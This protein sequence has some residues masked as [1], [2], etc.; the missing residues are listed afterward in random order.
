MTDRILVIEDEPI[1]RS[2]IVEVLE[3]AGFEVV[4]A[5]R[6]ENGLTVLSETSVSLVISD[7]VMPGI[8]GLQL[9]ETVRADHPSLPVVLV[10]GAGTYGNLTQALASG[11]SGIVVKPFSHADL[12]RA[13]HSA[14]GRARASEAE[15]RDRIV[16]PTVAAALA[17]AIEARD[18]AMHGHCERL[19][20]LAVAIAVE[21]GLPEPEQETIRL[22]GLLHDVGKI[23]IADSI[24]LK[25]GPLSEEEWVVMRTHPLIGDRLLEPLTALGEVRLGVRHHHERWDGSGYPDALAGEAIP[26]A[27]RVV[28][29]ADA[30]EAMSANRPYRKA[31]RPA[32]I[33]RQLEEGLGGQWD[34]APAGVALDLIR[35]GRLVFGPEGLRLTSHE[36]AVS[37]PGGMLSVL[38]VEDD[39]DHASLVSRVI[40]RA[41]DDVRVIHAADM[42]SAVKLLSDCTWSLAVLDHNLPDGSGLELLDQLR[43]ADPDVPVLMMT[44]EGSERL[45]VEAFRRGA[46]DYVVKGED[47]LKE[48]Q[49]RVQSLLL[50][51]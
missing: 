6:A 9:L 39:P 34:P 22:A 45:A 28:A 5:D 21:L 49:T 1:V 51:A 29:V 18:V 8:S 30:I 38:L 23:G 12:V 19:A 44:G 40:K 10:T 13:V 41:S 16:T 26:Y 17:N 47:S 4:E 32:A 20:S 36:E 46:S 15:V 27:A 11:A 7:I 50:A 3:D 14:L 48:L 25:L 31:L 33:V 35:T 43:S 37:T 24:L 2:L 42:A